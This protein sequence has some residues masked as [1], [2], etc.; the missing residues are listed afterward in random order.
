[1]NPRTLSI[2]EAA[3]QDYVRTGNPVSSAELY[4]KYD[5]G[6]KPAMIRA[7][8]NKLAEAGFL[9]QP[10][11]SGGRVP[12]DRG[13]EFVVNK[14]LKEMRLGLD[15]LKHG[16]LAK[17][18]LDSYLNN[19]VSEISDQLKLLS[20]GYRSGKN[21]FY[22]RGFDSLVEKLSLES[23]KDLIEVAR[24]FELLDK[25]VAKMSDFIDGNLPRVFVGRSPVTQ[26]RHLS[27]V[28]DFFQEGDDEFLVMVIGPKRMD[29]EK[30]LKRFREI[31][32]D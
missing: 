16:L 24:D 30:V 11:T 2:L 15:N 9:E 32:G 20:V 19:L 14:T 27:V 21:E 18:F 23:K 26:S 29:Y 5:F 12:T 4:K 22:K 25:R 6:V 7:E 10:H 8:L 28:A 13:Y 3:I 17:K 31:S 1:M